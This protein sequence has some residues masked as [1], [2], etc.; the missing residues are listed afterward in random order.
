MDWL[1]QY[2]NGLG[3]YKTSVSPADTHIWGVK[4][5][6]NNVQQRMIFDATAQ[7][8]IE[9]RHLV[10]ESRHGLEAHGMSQHDIACGIGADPGS[11]TVQT[12]QGETCTDDIARVTM[13]GWSFGDRTLT[14]LDPPYNPYGTGFTY[15][16]GDE[17]VRHNGAAWLYESATE[18][19]ITITYS[20]EPWP[21]LADWPA[22]YAA[23]KACPELPIVP[24]LQEIKFGITTISIDVYNYG[25]PL[26]PLSGFEYRVN[27]GEWIPLAISVPDPGGDSSYLLITGLTQDVEYTVDVRGVG[28]LGAGPIASTVGTTGYR[29]PAPPNL[30]NLN[31]GDGQLDIEIQ[32]ANENPQTPQISYEYRVDEGVWIPLAH[33]NSQYTGFVVTNLN[34]GT[35]YTIDI[36]SINPAGASATYL[37]VQGTPATVPGAPT[38]NNAINGPACD[39]II[40]D[41]TLN[42]DGG[43]PIVEAFAQVREAIDGESFG[44]FSLGLTSP[45]TL[46]IPGIGGNRV[47]VITIAVNAIGDSAESDY[48][49]FDVSTNNCNIRVTGSTYGFIN[50]TFNMRNR[51]YQVRREDVQPFDGFYYN[52]YFTTAS[53]TPSGA[54]DQIDGANIIMG[55]NQGL[56]DISDNYTIYTNPNRWSYL[57][58]SYDPDTGWGFTEAFYN[59]STS[60]TIPLG[61]WTANGGWGSNITVS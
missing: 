6:L 22:P 42:S 27:A 46:T 49:E 60:S 59:D 7:S 35:T 32:D 55:P 9:Y 13:T 57:L 40:V 54:N 47:K 50:G 19:L 10:Q 61:T 4:P 52:G 51:F 39:Q 56:T 37:T 29:L 28:L 8:E 30:S 44:V 53:Y 3:E 2:L 41:Y 1:D 43:S 48:I 20:M 23:T 14:Q 18:G 16:Y 58:Y 31:A 15:A 25:G 12:P 36:R 34:N 33:G 21:W 17:V 45:K 26:H 38:L 11:P 5:K 24:S